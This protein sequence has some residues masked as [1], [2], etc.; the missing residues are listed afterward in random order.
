MIF[1][2]FSYNSF[3]SDLSLLR[4]DP[5]IHLFSSLTW[6]PTNT[7]GH[8][9]TIVSNCTGVHQCHRL[10]VSFQKDV[11]VRIGA[12]FSVC[13]VSSTKGLKEERLC[14]TEGHGKKGEMAG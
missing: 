6:W 3:C 7:V 11:P 8:L 5:L 10:P 2:Y 14:T 4:N 1:A 13:T 9:F 12:A